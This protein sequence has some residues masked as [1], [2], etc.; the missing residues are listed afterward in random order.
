M[1]CL[2]FIQLEGRYT[3]IFCLAGYEYD[4]VMIYHLV[5]ILLI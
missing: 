2:L 3:A 5:M 1:Q 4:L